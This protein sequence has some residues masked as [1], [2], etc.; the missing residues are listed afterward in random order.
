MD[1]GGPGG[2]V[3]G[4]PLRMRTGTHYGAF[5]TDRDGAR[6]E[7]LRSSRQHLLLSIVE[8]AEQPLSTSDLAE[9]ADETLGATAYHVRA[10]AKGGYIGW[11]GDRQGRGALQTFYIITAKGQAALRATRVDLLRQ[12]FGL[13][14]GVGGIPVVP[15]LDCVAKDEAAAA[16]ERW[17]PHYLDIIKAAAERQASANNGSGG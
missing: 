2:G 11:A 4:S 9:I 15:R 3:G 17:R 13:P 5:M 10:L 6:Q 7:P 14:P 16:L 8:A 12:V 1:R